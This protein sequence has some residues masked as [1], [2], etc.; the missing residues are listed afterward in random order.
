MRSRIL[1]TLCFI[2]VLVG[3]LSFTEHAIATQT[4]GETSVY[5]VDL[6]GDGDIDVLSSSRGDGKVNWYENNGS[7]S[8]TTNTITT[9]GW[10][11]AESFHPADIDADGDID[12]LV[13]LWLDNKIAWYE[14]DGSENFTA[15]EISI[16]STN[17]DGTT[18]RAKSVY[19]VDLNGDGHLEFLAG[20]DDGSAGEGSENHLAWFEN[21]GAE[22]F[23]EHVIS[24]TYD[25]I[26]SVYAADIDGDNDIDFLSSASSSDII[27]WYQ[28][29]GSN[30]FTPQTIASHSSESSHSRSIHSA[31]INGDGYIDVISPSSINT[32]SW[33]QNDG[34]GNFTTN[35]FNTN[36]RPVAVYGK[37]MDG[38]NDVDIIV[39]II[40]YPSF[41]NN[42][43]AWYE[44]DGSAN[45]TVH[46][47]STSTQNTQA[48]FPVDLDGDGDIDIIAGGASDGKIAW[49]ESSPPDFIA[50]SIP[51]GLAATPSDAQVV[52]TWT[53][54]SESDFSY[55]N[56][57]GGTSSSPT[58]LLSIVYSGTETYT[59]TGLTNGTTYYYRISAVDNSGNESEKS[60]D[61]NATP[62][63]NWTYDSTDPTMTIA[64]TPEM[65]ARSPVM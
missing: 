53:A 16:S 51:T 22:N 62:Q 36:E 35:T 42:K 31:D 48:V 41:T 34:S 4:A 38:D 24:T 56:L 40:D 19:A 30:N 59:H 26:S 57:Y 63:Y 58:E 12:V 23:T 3:Q 37:D 14:N 45:F 47:I 7:E 21:D 6:D 15:H 25:E 18:E 28:N 50:P 13:A 55:Y 65:K 9:N 61:V 17:S 49:Y 54:N 52:L 46:E 1:S 2:S 44:N 20:L 39:A 5:A 60:S 11:N 10:G 64:T 43:I 33:Y 32:T 29:D 8:F 27:A